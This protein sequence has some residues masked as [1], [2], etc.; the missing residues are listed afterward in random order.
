ML[1]ERPEIKVF[2]RLQFDASAYNVKK[3]G[4]KIRAIALIDRD[5]KEY[6]FFYGE[7]FIDATYEGDLAAAAGVPFRVGREGRAEF[8]EPMAGRIYKAWGGDVGEG[9]TYEGDTAIQAYNYRMCITDNPLNSV[10]ISKPAQYNWEEFVSLIDDVKSGWVKGMIHKK[11][12]VMNPVRLPNHKFDANNHHYSLLSTDLPEENWWYPKADW[13]WR[14]RFALRLRDYT[15]GLLWIAQHDTTLPIEFRTDCLKYGLCKDEYLDNNH[16]PRQVYV[17]EARRIEGEYFFTAHDALPAKNSERPPIHKTSVT[18]SHYAIDSHAMRKREANRVHLDGFISYHTKPYTVPFEVMLPRKSENLLVPVCV[19]ASHVGLGTLRMEPCWMALG[20]A[21]GLAS[22]L[23]FQQKLPVSKIPVEKL[24]DKLTSQKAVLVY[25][26]QV[27]LH[28]PDYA[29]IQ[30]AVLR[31]G[32]TAYKI[33]LEAKASA[34]LIAAAE[35]QIPEKLRS[36]FVNKVREMKVLEL[37]RELNKY[38]Q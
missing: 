7:Q 32:I 13:A 20:Q 4:N 38:W 28:H 18:A 26:E 34:D 37:L 22:A 35:N 5:K 6:R 16:F 3:E 21:A 14:D 33:D 19:S 27:P 25:V 24:Q 29:L 8:G 2:R 36:S 12:G 30:K 23:A 17:R 1:S 15:L 9:S 11:S 31:L 10:P